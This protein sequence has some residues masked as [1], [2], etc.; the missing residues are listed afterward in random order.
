MMV[1]TYI[2]NPC[3]RSVAKPNGDIF[4][5]N[6]SITRAIDADTMT[7]P[8]GVERMVVVDCI[9]PPP[10][11]LLMQLGNGKE[12]FIRR[13]AIKLVYTARLIAC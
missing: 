10:V 1:D 5:C 7:I 13:P 4:W 11:F 2:I 8:R 6:F 3:W 12:Q 9:P